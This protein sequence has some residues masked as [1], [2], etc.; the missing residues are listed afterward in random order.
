MIDK[1]VFARE[2]KSLLV[3]FGRKVDDANKEQGRRF[4]VFLSPQMDTETFLAAARSVWA[5]SRFFP[6]PADFLTSRSTEVW[7][8]VVKLLRG[9]SPPVWGG[10]Y[11]ASEWWDAWRALPP[12]AQE[13]ADA[14]G[15]VEQLQ[16]LLNTQSMRLREQWERS[17][18]QRAVS[19]AVQAIPAPRE[20]L[21]LARGG[22]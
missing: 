4:Y 9:Y 14:L 21:R 5:T 11:S 12:A 17:Y 10:A 6:R 22:E 20:S 18:E 1:T 19:D 2:W 16:R 3:R 13:A 15:D 8:E 7:A